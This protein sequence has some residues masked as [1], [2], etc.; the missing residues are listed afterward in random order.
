LGA[1]AAFIGKLSIAVFWQ[2]GGHV[3]PRSDFGDL[4][5]ILLGVRVSEQTERRRLARPVAVD[6]IPKYNRSNIPVESHRRSRLAR[7]CDWQ[8]G[9]VPRAY[10]KQRAKNPR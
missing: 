9:R 7:D 3:A 10:R 6:A 5:G 4:F 2:P 8:R 1:E